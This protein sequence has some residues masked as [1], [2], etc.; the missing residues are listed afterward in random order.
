VSVEANLD[1]AQIENCVV[2]EKLL[3]AAT[4]LQ[5]CGLH[6]RFAGGPAVLSGV[7]FEVAAGETVALIGAN[8]AGKSTLLRS[9]VR[10]I[11][12]DRGKVD[13]LGTRVDLLSSQ[14]LRRFRRRIG[15]VFQRHNLVTRLSALSNVIHGSQARHRGP[16][17][18]YQS[19][20]AADER[21][22]ALACLDQVGLADIASR[23]A[24]RLSGGQ[25]QRVAIARMLMQRP[26]FVLADE[27]VA[28][29][30][31]K[32]GTEIME[33]LCRLVRGRGLAMV[34]TSHNLEHAVAYSDRVVG[35]RSG[36]IDLNARSGELRAERLR[37]FFAGRDK[38]A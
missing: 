1:N 21:Y 30:D 11:D 32:A 20:A 16:R 26:H 14:G 17:G 25:S 3:A 34:F 19:L 31:P 7:D 12:P 27:P 28:S 24:D 33:L 13:L 36:R 6:K 29:L 38:A 8:G 35:L 18:W 4:Q 22:E 15:F 37:G 10:L 5:V 9:L 23:R 2:A